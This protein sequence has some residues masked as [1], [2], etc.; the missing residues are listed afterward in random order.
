MIQ[1]LNLPYPSKKDEIMSRYRPIAPKPQ[2]PTPNSPTTNPNS[3]INGTFD[4]SLVPEKFRQSPYLIN[5]WSH[6]QAR[7]TRTRKRGRT[8]AMAASCGPTTT[9]LKKQ[10]SNDHH[11]QQHHVV[12]NTSND[13]SSFMGFCSSSQLPTTNLSIQPFGVNVY[14]DYQQVHTNSKS[15]CNV[16]EL[17]LLSNPKPIDLNIVAADS[18]SAATTLEEKDLV[19]QLQVPLHGPSKTGVISP[20]PVR[21]VG[22]SI[23]IV[24]K[25]SEDP[26]A[27]ILLKSAQEV[28]IG[29]E[30]EALP[31]VISDRKN[32]VRMVNSAY[33]EL[34][35]QPECPWLDSMFSGGGRISGEVMLNGL[36]SGLPV[37]SNGFS[38]WVRIEWEID[39]KKNCVN[40]FSEV[41]KL[42]C[43]SKD[44]LFSWR[45]HT[46]EI[47]PS[48]SKI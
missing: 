7:P 40:A 45:F 32:K 8:S 27:Q 16:V 5:I 13:P 24:G 12:V 34:I 20:R 19:L 2:L 9:L 44:Y 39:G 35:G 41:M 3:S 30:A 10:Q 21:P 43:F 18:E 15:T 37:S 6:L 17:P 31:A 46:R 29:A 36:E 42:A 26:E 1:A 14:T 23:C 33:K 47:S 25:I 22:S 11:Q 48:G 4:T 28:E 38:C